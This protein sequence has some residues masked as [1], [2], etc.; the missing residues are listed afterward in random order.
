MASGAPFLLALTVPFHPDRQR[1]GQPNVR[2]LCRPRAPG[3]AADRLH[4][5]QEN[6]YRVRSTRPPSRGSRRSAEAQGVSAS[7]IALIVGLAG[8]IRDA[9]GDEDALNQL[10]DDLDASTN[11]LTAAISA[12]SGGGEP[13]GG[14]A[15]TGLGEA[16]AGSDQS[17][18]GTDTGATDTGDGAGGEAE[19]GAGEPESEPQPE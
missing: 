6:Q 1:K 11:Q 9:I 8:Q 2:D 17:G 19:A 15:D 12:N 16:G 18:T 4:W 13:I 14:G 10:A 3:T 5:K 7:A